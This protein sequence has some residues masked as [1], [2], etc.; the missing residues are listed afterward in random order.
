MVV[1]G[2]GIQKTMGKRARRRGQIPQPDHSLDYAQT[3]CG[4][5]RPFV[6]FPHTWFALFLELFQGGNHGAQKL[7]DD[8]GADIGHDAQSE[9]GAQPEV[10]AGKQ[11]QVVADLAER[12]RSGVFYK[13]AEG[14]RIHSG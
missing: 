10:A 11:R 1:V 2:V 13:R 12:G 6:D 4:V 14:M 8:R 3:D 7:E 5:A 9:D